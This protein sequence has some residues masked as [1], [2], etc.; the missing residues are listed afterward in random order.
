MSSKFTFNFNSKVFIQHMDCNDYKKTSISYTLKNKKTGIAKSVFFRKLRRVLYSYYFSRSDLSVRDYFF[1]INDIIS[2]T[3][4]TQEL[5][6][7]RPRRSNPLSGKTSRTDDP[8]YYPEKEVL[9]R[10]SIS[11]AIENVFIYGDESKLVSPSYVFSSAVTKISLIR[12]WAFAAYIKAAVKIAPAIKNRNHIDEEELAAKLLFGVQSQ[13][14]KSLKTVSVKRA[15]KK[16]L[17]KTQYYAFES[18]RVFLAVPIERF[19]RHMKSGGELPASAAP[20]NQ[21]PLAFNYICEAS[22]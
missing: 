1:R 17:S 2:S 21:I 7:L 14:L 20:R 9:T 8:H 18:L 22:M 16:A 10:C 12:E 3:P 11:T 19:W 15:L 13:L 5:L 4:F 6:E